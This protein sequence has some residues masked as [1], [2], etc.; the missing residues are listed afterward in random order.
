MATALFAETLKTCNIQRGSSPKAEVTHWTPAAK[1]QGQESKNLFRLV[2]LGLDPGLYHGACPI[3]LY[4]QTW[5]PFGFKNSSNRQL[6]STVLL[7]IVLL[8]LLLLAFF[9]SFS[10][11]YFLLFSPSFS[12]FPISFPL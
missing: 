7:L 11:H 2:V 9:P 6:F 1:T 12:F 8:L 10:S 4:R 3:C 5:G